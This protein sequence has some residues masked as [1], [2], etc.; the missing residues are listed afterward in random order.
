MNEEYLEYLEYLD[1][2]YGLYEDITRYLNKK[3]KVADT[4]KRQ[5]IFDKV[6]TPYYYWVRETKEKKEGSALKINISALLE[7]AKNKYGLTATKSGLKVSKF[8]AAEEFKALVG[9][10]RACGYEY[11][12]E[13]REFSKVVVNEQ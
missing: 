2:L 7:N 10:M 8:L 13:E 11:G 12:R 3:D 1:Y 4:A 5:M 9:V 6:A